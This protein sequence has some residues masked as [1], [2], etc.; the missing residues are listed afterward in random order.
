MSAFISLPPNG[1]PWQPQ[2]QVVSGIHRPMNR[3]PYMQPMNPY[4]GQ[5]MRPVP[6]QAAYGG[7]YGTPMSAMSPMSQSPMAAAPGPPVARQA[8]AGADTVTIACLGDSLTM[9]GYPNELKKLLDEEMRVKNMAANWRVLDC[10]K[11]GAGVTQ[12]TTMPYGQMPEFQKGIGCAPDI[13]MVMLGTNDAKK[14]IWDMAGGEQGFAQAYTMML[15]QLMGSRNP[16]PVVILLIPPPL[17]IDGAMQMQ[18]HIINGVLPRVTTQIGQSLG[19]EVIDAFTEFGGNNLDKQHMFDEDGVH[20][21]KDIACPILA[22]LVFPSVLRVAA[23]KVSAIGPWTG[24]PRPPPALPI[25]LEN[26]PPPIKASEAILFMNG[27]QVSA[28]EASAVVASAGQPVK[29]NS[30]MNRTPLRAAPAVSRG[31][32]SAASPASTPQFVQQQQH[33]S[34]AMVVQNGFPAQQRPF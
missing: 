17:Y 6:T 2:Q 3:S 34:P 23:A 33:G 27:K 22:K 16:P 30:F 19:L 9:W 1:G 29:L 4:M 31:A 32:Y 11:G 25:S 14:I 13:A 15:R 21:N 20:F 18:Q 12:A 8:P 28:A 7:A 5:Q 26:P 10:G 24:P